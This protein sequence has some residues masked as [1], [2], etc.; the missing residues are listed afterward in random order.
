MSSLKPV[1]SNY[2]VRGKTITFSKPP[3]TLSPAYK[4]KV[5]NIPKLLKRIE[6]DLFEGNPDDTIYEIR[7]PGAG[8]EDLTKAEFLSRV[9]REVQEMSRIEEMRTLTKNATRYFESM[10]AKEE[11][12]ADV[13]RRQEMAQRG[14]IPEATE[15]EKAE[16]EAKRAEEMERV[17]REIEEEERRQTEPSDEGEFVDVPPMTPPA[18]PTAGDASEQK[19]AEDEDEAGAAV[20][21]EEARKREAETQ[22]R[23]TATAEAGVGGRATMTRTVPT[24]TGAAVAT[25]ETQT[26]P[27]RPS[28]APPRPTRGAATQTRRLVED[29]GTQEPE[30]ARGAAVGFEGD[31]SLMSS[32]SSMSDASASSFGGGAGGVVPAPEAEVKKMLGE[33]PQPSLDPSTEV[34]LIG[35]D[36][37]KEMKEANIIYKEAFRMVFNDRSGVRELERF[38]AGEESKAGESKSP[39]SLYSE[40]EDIRRVYEDQMKIPKLV[41]GVV[42]DKKDLKAQ[43]D[44]LNVLAK[45]TNENLKGKPNQDVLGQFNSV[46]VVV[47]ISNLG[48]NLQDFMNYINARNLTNK[49][50]KQK[51][52]NKLSGFQKGVNLEDVEPTTPEEE[53]IEPIPTDEA[54]E[55]PAQKVAVLGK[56]EFISNERIKGMINVSGFKKPMKKDKSKRVVIM[57]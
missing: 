40:A 33:Q 26:G 2:N 9:K 28:R 4:E 23:K 21:T 22:T 52:N 20:S 47:D 35:P 5:K 8:P 7:Y 53:K 3:K 45:G 55:D 12:R 37:A 13:A 30:P 51:G 1:L 49:T 56:P 10:E 38:R 54:T 50:D 27:M 31:V 14:E 6:E 32:Q 29:A 46:G 25:S 17:R 16:E 11:R 15:E 41:Y 24:Q 44:E 18:S 39:E 34:A 48:M 36:S 42:D 19:G 43:W 57:L